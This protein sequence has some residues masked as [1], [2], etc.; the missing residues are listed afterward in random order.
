MSLVAN[1]D[2]ISNIDS[3]KKEKIKIAGIYIRY[4]KNKI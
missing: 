3:D 4:I 1:K 2:A